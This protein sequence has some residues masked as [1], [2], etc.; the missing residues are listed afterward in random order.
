MSPYPSSSTSGNATKS[1]PDSGLVVAA[2]EHFD[3]G[4]E[5]YEKHVQE[6]PGDYAAVASNYSQFLKNSG[7]PKAAQVLDK[8]VGK[9][10]K[11]H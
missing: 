11:K 1:L 9:R 6:V 10:L 7:D 4:L 5:I 2:K 8:R 3:K